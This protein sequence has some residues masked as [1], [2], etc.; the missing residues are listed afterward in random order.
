MGCLSCV[1]VLILGCLSHC[2]DVCN[3][4]LHW[5]ALWRYLIVCDNNDK[6]NM[7]QKGYT[8]NENWYITFTVGLCCSRHIHNYI[9]FIILTNQNEKLHTH[10]SKISCRHLT[11][12]TLCD[13]DTDIRPQRDWSSCVHTLRCWL[14]KM[15]LCSYL[16]ML[17]SKVVNPSMLNCGHQGLH[18][19]K[20]Q[21]NH[22]GLVML[23]GN[24]D[25]SQHWLR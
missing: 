1:K 4:M 19:D 14:H 17:T 9:S 8:L 21:F 15:H 25:L 10:L 12:R 13:N 23:Y 6:G 18:F 22:C 20:H 16:K 2:S 24:I 11:P 7:C 3:I 5:T